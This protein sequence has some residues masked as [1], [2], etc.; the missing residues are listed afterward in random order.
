MQWTRT[1]LLE[2]HP[3]IICVKLIQNWTRVLGG[4]VIVSKLLTEDDDDGQRYINYVT[5]ELKTQ[6][7]FQKML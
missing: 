4:V 3:R 1:I 2:C 5:G 6:A 7:T